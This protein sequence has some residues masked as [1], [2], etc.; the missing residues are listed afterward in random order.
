MGVLRVAPVGLCIICYGLP[1]VWSPLQGYAP[2]ALNGSPRWSLPRRQG[3]AKELDYRG[4]IPHPALRGIKE[5]RYREGPRWGKE[6]CFGKGP[7]CGKS[8]S[9]GHPRRA[10]GLQPRA[11]PNGR[12][13]PYRGDPA[14]K[15][16]VR[17]PARATKPW[18]RQPSIQSSVGPCLGLGRSSCVLAPLKQQHSPEA[19]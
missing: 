18:V 5:P 19:S 6:P 9:A 13:S 2:W 4:I 8:R 14:P 16:K 10:S 12:A 11:C 1:R 17:S 7:C 15:P 3:T